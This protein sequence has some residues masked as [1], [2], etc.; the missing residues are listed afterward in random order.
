MEG[1]KEKKLVEILVKGKLTK[2][3]VLDVGCGLQKFML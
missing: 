3:A 1:D 2:T